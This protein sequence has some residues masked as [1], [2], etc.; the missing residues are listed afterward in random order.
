MK[1]RVLGVVFPSIRAQTI[2]VGIQ[3]EGAIEGEGMTFS[4][5]DSKRFTPFPKSG[6]DGRRLRR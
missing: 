1:H 2:L 6:K 3:E 4:L 5:K